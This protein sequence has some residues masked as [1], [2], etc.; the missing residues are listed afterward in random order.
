[1]GYIIFCLKAKNKH[2]NLFLCG[3]W[4]LLSPFL[5]I[6]FLWLPYTFRSFSNLLENIFKACVCVW[7]GACECRCTWRPEVLDLPGVGSMEVVSP[8]IWMLR[9]R[10]FGRALNA[11]SEPSLSFAITLLV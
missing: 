11:P 4:Y 5:E 3:P 1:M 10:S 9:I 6:F 2:H 8:S 7:A